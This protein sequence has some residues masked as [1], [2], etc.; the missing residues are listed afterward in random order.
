MT[1]AALRR[2]TR[3]L[4][5][6]ARLS[7][8]QRCATGGHVKLD[9]EKMWVSVATACA[10]GVGLLSM[11]GTW[12]AFNTRAQ[13]QQFQLEAHEK[14]LDQRGVVLEKLSESLSRIETDASIIRTKIEYL[15][16]RERR[17]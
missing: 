6:S 12:V 8:D 2:T 7:K 13:A 15:E 14:I 5:R 3:K 1:A 10:L 11:V 4:S 16:R 17:R 9:P